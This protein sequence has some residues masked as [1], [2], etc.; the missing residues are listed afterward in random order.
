MIICVCR[1]ISESHVEQHFANVPEIRRDWI[2]ISTDISGKA[3][4]CNNGQGCCQEYGQGLVDL[5]TD[6]PAA[7][8]A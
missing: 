6:A 3:P 1:Q 8:P 4:I 7:I 5:L 2:A